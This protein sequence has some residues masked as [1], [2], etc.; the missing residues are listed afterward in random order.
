MFAVYIEVLKPCYSGIVPLH[1]HRI[2]TFHQRFVL[3]VRLVECISA[4]S[5]A[6]L[7]VLTRCMCNNKDLRASCT[8]VLIHI[9]N[10][11]ICI[12]LLQCIKC[13][14][15]FYCV[16]LKFTCVHTCVYKNVRRWKLTWKVNVFPCLLVLVAEFPCTC[17][18]YT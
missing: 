1:T 15:E 8:R 12:H 13:S 4:R 10:M 17:V 14:Q 3:I 2:C 16:N 18:V 11:Y 6:R 9:H 5:Q 7:V